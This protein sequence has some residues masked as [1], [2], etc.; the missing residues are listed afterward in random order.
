MRN[1]TFILTV[2]AAVAGVGAMFTIFGTVTLTQTAPPTAPGL[3][4]SQWT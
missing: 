1:W 3:L 2:A 4:I